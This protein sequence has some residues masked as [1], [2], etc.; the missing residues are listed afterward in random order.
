MRDQSTFTGFLVESAKALTTIA[1][2]KEAL[3]DL[4]EHADQTFQAIGSAAVQTSRRGCVELPVTL[5]QGNKTF[6]ELPPDVW[7][8]SRSW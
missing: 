1:A 3:T 6:T 4:V 5:N 7:P 2:R 8:R